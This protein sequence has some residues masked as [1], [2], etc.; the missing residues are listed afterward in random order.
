MERVC[1]LASIGWH[2]CVLDDFPGVVLM[3]YSSYLRMGQVQ[4]GFL[5]IRYRSS[6][7]KTK[8]RME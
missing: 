4:N 1:V 5:Y 8:Q 3:N 2:H 6:S 7:R